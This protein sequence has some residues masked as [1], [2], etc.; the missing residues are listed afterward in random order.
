MT[1]DTEPMERNGGDDLM[2]HEKRSLPLE[3]RIKGGQLF[4]S[5]GIDTLCFATQFNFEDFKITD[6]EGFAKDILNELEREEE[7]GTTL[8]H[9]MFDQAANSAVEDGSEYVEETKGEI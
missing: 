6:R 3:V 7:D 2:E 1:E 9:K 8:V 5:I 4:I